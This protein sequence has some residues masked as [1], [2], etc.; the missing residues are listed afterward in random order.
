[1]RRFAG[2]TFLEAGWIQLGDAP[3]LAVPIADLERFA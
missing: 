1:V 3:P 2:G